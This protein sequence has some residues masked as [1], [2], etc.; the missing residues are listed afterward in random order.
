MKKEQLEQL[1]KEF[2]E[3]I[4]ALVN[5]D[6]PTEFSNGWNYVEFHD[7]RKW[8]VLNP[9]IKGEVVMSDVDVALDGNI[10]YSNNRAGFCGLN[11]I[12]SHRPATPS[13]IQEALVK[14]CTR[15][16]IVEGATIERGHWK[17]PLGKNTLSEY[18]IFP[19]TYCKSSDCLQLGG[20]M[21]YLKG[22]FATVVKD[23]VI[24]IGGYEVKFSYYTNDT[25]IDGNLF[26]KEFWQAAKLIS[27]HSKAKIM[28]GC[29]KQFDV[30]LETI[31]KIL[32]KL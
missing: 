10:F 11:S 4:D 25:K 27:E 3:R 6:K 9:V 26:T 8:L 1:R 2:N 17:S 28:V 24:K 7:G 18:P 32:S 30:S 23:E 20:V 16:G 5:E 29:S 15:L 21:V 22:Q 31:N 12:K 14:E 13:E 19:T